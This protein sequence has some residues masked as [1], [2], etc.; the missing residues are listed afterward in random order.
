MSVETT[1]PDRMP[2]PEQWLA[3]HEPW[4]TLAMIAAVVIIAVIVG[5]FV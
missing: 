4:S 3:E 5:R 2:Q 1:T